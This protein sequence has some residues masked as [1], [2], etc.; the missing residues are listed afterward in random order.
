LKDMIIKTDYD[1]ELMPVIFDI[2]V[3]RDRYVN[4]DGKLIDD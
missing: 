4:R 2:H 3:I 1:D